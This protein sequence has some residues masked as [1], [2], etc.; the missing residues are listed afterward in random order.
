MNA[1]FSLVGVTKHSSPPINPASSNLML[2]LYKGM[3]LLLTLYEATPFVKLQPS[4]SRM[5]HR[6]LFRSLWCQIGVPNT[7]S[8]GTH[9][10]LMLMRLTF[11]PMFCPCGINQTWDSQSGRLELFKCRH[12][13]HQLLIQRGTPDEGRMP[14]E[15]IKTYLFALTLVKQKNWIK[16]TNI[17][18]IWITNQSSS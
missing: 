8:T 7:V 17:S 1:L 15:S 16:L 11:I 9:A 4:W 10:M 6:A 18:L 3:L 13:V 5:Y 2:P 12:N 14:R